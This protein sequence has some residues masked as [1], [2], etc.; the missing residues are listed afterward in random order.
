MPDTPGVVGIEAGTLV[1]RRSPHA[2][3]PAGLGVVIGPTDRERQVWAPDGAV[4]VLFEGRVVSYHPRN[5]VPVGTSVG[6]SV[7]TDGDISP[8]AV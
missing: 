3:N 4:D 6:T 8:A 5:L 7:G 1:R 2:K